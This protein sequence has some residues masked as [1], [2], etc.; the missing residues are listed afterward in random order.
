MRFSIL[1]LALA[2]VVLAG[3]TGTRSNA[4]DTIDKNGGVAARMNPSQSTSKWDALTGAALADSD[5]DAVQSNQRVAVDVQSPN[6]STGP[7][8]QIAPLV[9][10]AKEAA[11]ILVYVGPAEQA[12]IDR[13][14]ANEAALAAVNMRLDTDPALTPTERHALTEK[15]KAYDDALDPLLVKL[16]EY[17][18]KKFEAATAFV[19]DLSSLAEITYQIITNTN[20][21]STSPNISD[22]AATAIAKV[23]EAAVTTSQTA[24]AGD[25]VVD[26]GGEAEEG[27]E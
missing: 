4:C 18:K 21:G 12:V 13:L 1:V 17:A 7:Q 26:Q 2:A 24:E 9:G 22:H 25:V 11:K 5:G 23:A 14:K 20:A 15:A 19:P 8:I 3:C 10:D 16:D 27:G 6:Q